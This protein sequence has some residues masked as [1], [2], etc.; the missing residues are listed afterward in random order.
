MKKY[1]GGGKS[2]CL[3]SDLN[4]FKQEEKQNYQIV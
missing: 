3:D 1:G 4:S 2:L